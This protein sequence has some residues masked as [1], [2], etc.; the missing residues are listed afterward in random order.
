MI[1][2]DNAYWMARLSQLIYRCK[3]GSTQTDE[4]SVL[5]ELQ[6]EDARFMRLVSADNNSAQGMLV[7]HEHY[8][9]FVF[10]GTDEF[11]D[12]LDNLNTLKIEHAFG[13]FH[14]GFWASCEDLWPDLY[15]A[16]QQFQKESLQSCNK[17]KAVF[18][19]GHSM[20]GAMAAVAAVKLLQHEVNFKSVYTFGQPRV[21]ELE[22]AQ[23]FNR[24]YG[25]KYFR[26]HNNRDFITRFPTRVMGY[27]HLGTHLH[28]TETGS[29]HCD[30]SYWQRFLDVSLGALHE[31][32]QLG[33]EGVQDHHIDGY[34]EAIKRW[35]FKHRA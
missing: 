33:L 22:T 11:V 23:T 15:P 27:G 20:G 1:N 5:R 14:R 30:P 34:V 29:I 18:L 28:I 31:L 6:Q 12:W 13:R 4:K 2:Q 32:V 10:R 7:E 35:D 16:Y 17:N 26:F 19:T 24:L 9:S 8:L 21:A 25:K 3:P